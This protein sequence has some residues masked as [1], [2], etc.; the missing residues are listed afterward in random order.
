M[1]VRKPE[2]LTVLQK[3]AV[4][5]YF[6]LLL[7]PLGGFVQREGDWGGALGSVR[8]LKLAGNTFLLAS[9]AALG[10]MAVG[11]AAAAWIHNGPLRCRRIRWFFLLLAPVPYYVYALTW[12]YLVRLLGRIDR[13]LMR[14][15]ASGLA[16]C[17]FVNILS[18]LPL[19]T[20]VILITMEYHD[21]RAEEMGSIY[22]GGNRVFFDIVLPAVF[23]AVLAAGALVFVL[24]AT[25]FSVPSLFQYQTHTLEIFSEYSRTGDLGQTGILALP[26]IF[27]V[28]GLLVLAG[29]GLG[30]I[31]VR[32]SPPEGSGLELSGSLRMAGRF[33]VSVCILQI[34]VPAVLFAL[35]TGAPTEL[36]ESFRLCREELLISVGIAALSAGTA[37]L[38]A[39]PAAVWLEGKKWYCFLP[40]LFP[41]AIPSSLI[42]MGLLKTVNGSVLHGISQTLYFPALGCAIKYMPFALLLFTARHRRIH[43]EELEAGQVYMP[44]GWQYFCKIL[45]PVY[46]PAI[47]GAAGVV[48][49]LTLGEEGIPLILMPPGYET[50]AVKVYNYL[51]YGASELVSGF[52]LI[53]VLF[54]AGMFTLVIRQGRIREVFEEKS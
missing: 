9:M 31:P 28:L 37:V 40:A 17:I 45:I 51:H 44:S 25:D 33:A 8:R 50:L 53:T 49:L 5:L 3:A 46:R 43:R 30:T 32:K 2:G 41:I 54:T 47:V 52:C 23:P 39:G 14:S 21:R 38:L 12:M 27:P 20:G 34:G 18:F 16:P 48:F 15:L 11:L 7:L 29:R 26:V 10:C 4:L 13:S 22:A 6:V 1:P 19:A 35:Q 24:S 36:W 42:G